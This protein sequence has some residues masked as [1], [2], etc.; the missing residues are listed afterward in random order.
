MINGWLEPGTLFSGETHL[1]VKK[2]LET[3]ALLFLLTCYQLGQSNLLLSGMLDWNSH[4]SDMKP[5]ACNIW[6][7]AK[8][9]VWY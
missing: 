6:Y 2:S 1:G 8:N 5:C 9:P 4:G 7:T 3:L